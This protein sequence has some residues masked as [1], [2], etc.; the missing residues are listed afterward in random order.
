MSKK[1]SF[2]LTKIEY[3]TCYRILITSNVQTMAE[4]RA[5]NEILDEMESAG[6]A[7]GDEVEGLPQMFSIKPGTPAQL[8]IS[9][10]SAKV[11]AE[12]IESGISRFQ[13]WAVRSLPGVVDTLKK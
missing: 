9:S 1:I 12:H 3:E 10:A 2:E 5:L 13:T 7:V 6:F 8:R 11:M 4:Q